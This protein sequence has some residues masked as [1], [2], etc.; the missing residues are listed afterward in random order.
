MSL[1]VC[2]TFK[3]H[4]TIVR[5]LRQGMPSAVQEIQ[6]TPDTQHGCG[7]RAAA[8]G[9]ALLESG[10]NPGAVTASPRSAKL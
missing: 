6:G 8:G 9:R 5:R 1:V 3:A 4:K 10:R 7:F 2:R